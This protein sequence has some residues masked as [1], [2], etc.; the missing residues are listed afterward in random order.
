MTARLNRTPNMP[1][2]AARDYRWLPQAQD[3]PPGWH[4]GNNGMALCLHHRY[5]R[6]IWRDV[7]LLIL[8][9]RQLL[10]ATEQVTG[11]SIARLRGEQRARPVVRARWA[12]T[13]AAHSILGA[14]STV[15]GRALNQDHSTVLCGLK[16]ARALVGVDAEFTATAAEISAALDDALGGEDDG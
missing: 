16:Q 1:I 4:E 8:P 15:I 10:A 6:L 3:P 2:G 7:D 11:I 5:Q 13:L 12:F 14:S 9:M